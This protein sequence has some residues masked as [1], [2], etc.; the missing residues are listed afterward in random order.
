LAGLS[1]MFVDSVFIEDMSVSMYCLTSP[2]V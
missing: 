1:L 2:F